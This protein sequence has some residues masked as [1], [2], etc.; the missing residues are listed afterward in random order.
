MKK[1]RWVSR[2]ALL[3]LHSESLAEHGGIRGLRDAGLL[4][5]ALSRPVNAFAYKNKCDLA[6]LAAAYA[7]GLSHNHP[8][9]DGNKRAAFL[10]AALFLELN[11]RTLIAD[12]LDAIE[13]FFALADGKVSE[14]G[15]AA[16]FRRNLKPSK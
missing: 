5:S 13:M 9:N 10:A 3:L 6:D 16:W 2:R 1:P 4:D 11:G 8:F 12:P 15:L 7:Y 14:V